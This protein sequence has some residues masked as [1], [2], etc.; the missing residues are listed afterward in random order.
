MDRTP[1]AIEPELLH[2]LK[3]KIGVALGFCDLLLDE[4]EPTGDRHDD[5]THMKEAL[6]EALDM[7]P[8]VAERMK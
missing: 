7:M 3:N 5:L 8:R 6:T 4:C 1:T 2:T